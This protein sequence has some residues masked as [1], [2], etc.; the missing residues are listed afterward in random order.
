MTVP[1]HSVNTPDL[2]FLADRYADTLWEPGKHRA[3]S[4][5]FVMEIHEYMIA[6]GLASFDDSLIDSL[7]SNFRSKKNRNSTINRKLAALYKVLKKAE[8]SGLI[9]RLPSY[10][11]LQ[12]KN[13]RIRFFTRDEEASF[14]SEMAKRNDDHFRLCVFLIDTGARVGEALSLKWSDV[15]PD[16]ATFWITKSGRSRTIP[17]TARASE[18]VFCRDSTGGPF[19]MIKYPKF[20]YDWNAVKKTIGLESDKQ[21]VPH[22]LRHTCASRLVQAGID[23]RRVQ[24]F[25]GH[26]TIQMTLRYAHLATND[27]N[28]CV[29]A[30]EDFGQEKPVLS[31]TSDREGTFDRRA[32]QP[33]TPTE[34]P[35][36]NQRS[37]DA[38]LPRKTV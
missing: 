2:K 13:G 29:A 9:T 18:A 36:S 6:H 1:L 35:A 21:L 37:D 33:S 10:V 16:R 19:A 3:S 22:I 30:L 20:L 28:Q 31:R 32:P 11:R 12:E 34:P 26:Q 27:L 15:T 17:L 23:L 38:I 24:T 14:F 7:I 5:S 25:L 8:R 4:L